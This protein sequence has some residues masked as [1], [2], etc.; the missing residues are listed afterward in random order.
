MSSL[1]KARLPLELALARPFTFL[2]PEKPFDSSTVSSFAGG[3]ARC[4]F[5][6]SA[7]VGWICL[8]ISGIPLVV[9]LVTYLSF[10]TTRSFRRHDRAPPT[11]PY[12]FPYFGHALSLVYDAAKGLKHMKYVD[13]LMLFNKTDINF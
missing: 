9:Y 4:Q 10:V 12:F 8:I 1:V 5:L 3:P 11:L 13:L 6:A 7:E 2:L